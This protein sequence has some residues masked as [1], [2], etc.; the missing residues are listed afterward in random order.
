M[1]TP[2]SIPRSDAPL[3]LAAIALIVL[4]LVGL[5]IK[6]AWPG[7]MLV[8]ALFV[9]PLLLIGYVM[10]IVI[11]ATGFLGRRAAFRSSGARTRALSAAWLT[12]VGVVVTAFFMIDGGDTGDWGSAFMHAVGRA[13]D[14][15]LGDISSA[16]S[17]IA[18]IAWVGG[19]VWLFIEWIAALAARRRPATA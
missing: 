14:S 10:Q 8:F 17:Y 19:W 1:S 13:S 2:T 9:S 4:P 7:W 6:F 15:E 18:G 5:A 12:S 11:A 3:T 16:V